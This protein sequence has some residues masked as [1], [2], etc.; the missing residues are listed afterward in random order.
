M[1]LVG[2]QIFCN[3]SYQLPLYH[4]SKLHSEDETRRSLTDFEFAF[5]PAALIASNTICVF[6]TVRR[7]MLSPTELNPVHY[8]Y[9][10]NIQSEQRPDL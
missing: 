4:Y 5:K 6:F 9:I 10:R 2:L 1:Y 8:T 3:I 7:F